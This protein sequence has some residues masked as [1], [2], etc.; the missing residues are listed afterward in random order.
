MQA[1]V[2]E[3]LLLGMSLLTLFNPP[4]S[5]AVFASLARPYPR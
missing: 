3:M 2:R 5:M 1:L 4:S